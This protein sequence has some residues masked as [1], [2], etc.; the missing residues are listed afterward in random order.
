L[1]GGVI[2]MGHMPHD[3]GDMHGE[4]DVIAISL[5]SRIIQ[6]PLISRIL[7][8]VENTGINEKWTNGG[9]DSNQ[10]GIPSSPNKY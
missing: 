4:G 5:I 8:L 2:D 3:D 9:N 10:R 1:V 7:V 6:L